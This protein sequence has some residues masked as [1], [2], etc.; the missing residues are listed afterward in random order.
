ME[1]SLLDTAMESEK[2]DRECK[3]DR[4]E[5]LGSLAYVEPASGDIFSLSAQL[6]ALS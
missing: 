3:D 5:R 6:F 4:S 2:Q 1:V